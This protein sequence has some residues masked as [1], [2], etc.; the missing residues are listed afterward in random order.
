MNMNTTHRPCAIFSFICY[1]HTCDS[2]WK[3]LWDEHTVSSLRAC[4]KAEYIFWKCPVF[5]FVHTLVGSLSNLF[6]CRKKETEKNAIKKSFIG[7]SAVQI[8]NTS[9]KLFNPIYTGI[10]MWAYGV[11]EKQTYLKWCYK[12]GTKQSEKFKSKPEGS[13]YQSPPSLVH[14]L[15]KISSMM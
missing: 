7:N 6:H 10:F 8:Y 14:D 9:A 2:E 5:M 4:C 13:G 3:L 15:S 11:G 1:V 12:A